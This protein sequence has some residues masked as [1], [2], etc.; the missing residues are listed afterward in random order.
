[1]QAVW[2]LLSIC[3][4]SV[5]VYLFILILLRI[6]GKKELAQL[7][8]VDLVFILLISNSVQ[9]AMVGTDYT[10]EGGLAA[11]TGLFVTNAVFKFFMR[12]SNSLSSLIQGEPIM[13]IYRGRLKLKN[14]E[15]TQ[16]SVPE[17]EAVVREHGVDSIADVDLAV[18]EVDGN[19][20]VLS[21]NYTRQSMRKRHSHKI[22][23]KNNF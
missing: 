19:V 16:L 20:S 8:T 14:L 21:H 7:S 4:K 6:F 15:K 10:L 13:L 17:L 22:I 9:N 18:F 23:S 12:R 3:G 1:M 11:A 2:H 5:A